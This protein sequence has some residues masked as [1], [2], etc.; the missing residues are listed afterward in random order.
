MVHVTMMLIMHNF[1][2]APTHPTT[3]R[4]IF[5]VV[6]YIIMY[7][8][9]LAR[10]ATFRIIYFTYIRAN[11][12]VRKRERVSRGFYLH[13]H[14]YNTHHIVRVFMKLG[15]NPNEQVRDYY[16][17]YNRYTHKHHVRIICPF[18]FSR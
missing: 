2:G 5:I 11:A 1:T 17:T 12:D 8:L 18:V 4:L 14:Y 3:C 9:V 7:T 10:S 13:I 15:E 6:I 16:L